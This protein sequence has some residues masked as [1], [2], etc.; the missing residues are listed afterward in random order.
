MVRAPAPRGTAVS[1]CP[2][3]RSR[4]MTAPIRA[5]YSKCRCVGSSRSTCDW[6]V[7][8]TSSSKPPANRDGTM[9]ATVPSDSRARGA[10]SGSTRARA[11]APP[12]PP[13]PRAVPAACAGHGGR[14]GATVGVMATIDLNADLGETVEGVP[15][16]D[17]E[18]MFA[19]IS[20][21]SV[22]CGGHAGD[23]ASM[24]EAV[25]RARRFGVAL[26]AHPSFPDR[27]GFG[28]VALPLDPDDLRAAVDAQLA[29]LAAA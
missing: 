21:A 15:T 8:P 1:G 19:V 29:D 26:G 10:S 3:I 20:S 13:S 5:T 6:G 23:A 2:G 24:R 18:A 28:R 16:T 22:A 17:D 27:A 11:M 4:S 25:D 9:R 14:L 7:P 12:Y